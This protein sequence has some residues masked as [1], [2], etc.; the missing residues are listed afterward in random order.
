VVEAA[1]A[2]RV[3]SEVPSLNGVVITSMRA[4]SVLVSEI[5]GSTSVDFRN[6]VFGELRQLLVAANAEI[7]SNLGFQI[8]AGT[9]M[10]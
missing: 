5:I 8:G 9:V 3:L 10:F 7:R 6:M 1:D 2:Q 4:V